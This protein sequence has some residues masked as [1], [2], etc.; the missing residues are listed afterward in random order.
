MNT[1]ICESVK[2]IMSLVL[3]CQLNATCL[4]KQTSIRRRGTSISKDIKETTS[5]SITVGSRV[6]EVKGAIQMI[7]SQGHSQ[8]VAR[9]CA[10]SVSVYK[11]IDDL[12]ELNND[13]LEV[14]FVVL[15]VD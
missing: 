5:K 9:G 1:F 10:V 8:T 11:Y 2:I 13:I 7:L 15:S 12:D 3:V 14:Q 4:I 6:L